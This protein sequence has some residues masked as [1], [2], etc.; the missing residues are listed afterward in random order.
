MYWYVKSKVK[1]TTLIFCMYKITYSVLGF[2][3]YVYYNIFIFKKTHHKN[4]TFPRHSMIYSV[5]L[6]KIEQNK[7]IHQ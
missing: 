2:H 3:F 5:C 1:L 4:S 6:V 7:A